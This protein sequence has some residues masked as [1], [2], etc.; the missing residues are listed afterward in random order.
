MF[1]VLT[2]RWRE[3]AQRPDTVAARAPGREDRHDIAV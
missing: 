2:W 3:L 1:R